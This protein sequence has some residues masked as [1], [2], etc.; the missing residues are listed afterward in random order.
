VLGPAYLRL[1]STRS[2]KGAG[3]TTVVSGGAV[4]GIGDGVARRQAGQRGWAVGEVELRALS[5]DIFKKQN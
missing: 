5:G 3:D 1:G 4:E 2:G